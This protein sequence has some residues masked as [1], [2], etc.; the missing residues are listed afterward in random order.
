MLAWHTL[1]TKPRMERRVAETLAGRGLEVFLPLLH[2]HGKRGDPL[3]KPYFPRYLFAR[4]DWEA[5]GATAV[6]WTPGLTRVVAFDGR[7]AVLDDARLEYLR[8]ALDEL[9]GDEYLALKPGQP[10]RLRRGPFADVNAVFDGRLNGP[11]RVT[12]LLQMLGRAVRV[13]VAA[14]DVERLA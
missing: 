3:G 5:C 1:F 7:P 2:Y 9:D 6:Q 12:V 4:L 11:Q 8:S 13:E 14:A 10:V